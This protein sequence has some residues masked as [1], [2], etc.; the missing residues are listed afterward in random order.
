MGERAFFGRRLARNVY[1]KMVAMAAMTNGRVQ[2]FDSKNVQVYEIN[3]K[4][5]MPDELG[6]ALPPAELEDSVAELM[7]SER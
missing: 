1:A 6:Q 7:E 2:P 4:H 5:R 3:G